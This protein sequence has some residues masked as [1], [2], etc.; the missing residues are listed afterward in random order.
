VSSPTFSG[1]VAEH[2]ARFRRGYPPAVIDRLTAVL[3]LDDRSRVLDL[4]CGT[5]QLA[6][7]LATRTHAVL[8]V[9]VEADMLRLARRAALDAHLAN[10]TWMLAADSE[11]GALG[12][13]LGEHRFDAVTIGQA[14]H[15][16]DPPRLFP[17]LRR[18]VR[19]GGGV[20]VIANGT[21]LWLQETSW[22]RALRAHLEAWVGRR[23]TAR[24]GTDPASRE[25]YRH[26]LGTAGFT[27]LTDTRVAYS[28]GLTF[29]QLV[30]SVYSAMTPDQLPRGDERARFERRLHD[31][32][33][34]PAADHVFV[35]HVEVVAL[36]G[37][38]A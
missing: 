17:T 3:G 28:D 34:C 5:G 14:L 19:P 1:E 4:G 36:V 10:T 32:L 29:T 26:L 8:G 24:C 15:W 31:A 33:G 35:E 27:H 7:P 13:L 30:G 37:T 38:S 21:P 16:M 2:Y 20:A 9:D 11:L 22:A 23:L 12:P 25:G 6:V 18:L